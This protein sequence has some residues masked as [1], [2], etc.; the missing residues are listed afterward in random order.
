MKRVVPPIRSTP[1][2]GFTLVE[3]LVVIA[4][5]GVLVALLLPAIQAAREAGRRTQCGNQMR[6][7]CLALQN[8]ESSLKIF[9]SGGIDPW[10]SIEDYAAGGKPFTAPKQGLSW[11]FQLLPYLEQNAVHN[12]V[13]SAQ[14][15]RTPVEL[16]FCPSRRPPT[17]NP[18][19]IQAD[20]AGN[21]QGRWLMDYAALVGA[22]TRNEASGTK[23]PLFWGPR[24]TSPEAFDQKLANGELC[25]AD[26]MY[27][28][29]RHLTFPPPKYDPNSNLPG[30]F[31][32]QGVIVRSDYVV[33]DGTGAAGNPE[34]YSFGLP[35][36][37]SFRQ[38]TDGA[39]N[40]AVL[41]EKRVNALYY[42][43]VGPNGGSRVPD[44]AGW[45]DGWDFDTLRLALCQPHNDAPANLG[46]EVE[47]M[48]PGAA[49]PGVFFCAFADGSVRPINYDVDLQSLNMMA[50]KADG[51]IMEDF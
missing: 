23:Q 48:T 50:N 16:Y 6:Q 1:G 21:L 14:L 51:Q 44:D 42:D 29:L 11:A 18:N 22:P 41:C 39:S 4:I 31:P 26:L 46:A 45:S 35:K 47:W 12:L 40:T 43:G 5:I 24:V 37:T 34:V 15:P 3:L 38:I 8:H 13:D 17:Q 27:G 36:P 19:S 28:R 25:N 49:H 7:M 20:G 10:P 33:K 2:S 9:P 30:I 32:T